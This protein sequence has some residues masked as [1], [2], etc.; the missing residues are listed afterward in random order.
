MVNEGK[1]ASLQRDSSM[2]EEEGIQ[3]GNDHFFPL[4]SEGDCDYSLVCHCSFVWCSSSSKMNLSLNI[5]SNCPDRQ[6][7]PG[8]WTESILLLSPLLPTI[9]ITH[10]TCCGTCPFSKTRREVPG[11]IRCFLDGPRFSPLL[12]I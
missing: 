5:H 11:R 2:S 9:C 12:T 3:P 6:V 1:E 7:T 4:A 10:K 8:S